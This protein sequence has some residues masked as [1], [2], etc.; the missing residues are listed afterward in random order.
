M[1]YSNN[2]IQGSFLKIKVKSTYG[3]YGGLQFIGL[4]G[5]NMHSPGYNPVY[6]RK[7]LKTKLLQINLIFQNTIVKKTMNQRKI[8]TFVK[9]SIVRNFLMLLKKNLYPPGAQEIVF[10]VNLELLLKPVNLL[11]VKKRKQF[12]F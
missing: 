6:K 11:L 3:D 2:K 10:A 5:F 8:Q 7:Y 1:F 9:N 12:V 4:T